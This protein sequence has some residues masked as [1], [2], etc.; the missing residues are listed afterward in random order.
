SRRPARARC[1][2]CRWRKCSHEELAVMKRIDWDLLDE[3]GHR[4]ALARPAQSR[5]AELRDGVG[6][7]IA[8]VRARGDV[9]L[10]ELSAKYD[11]CTLMELEAT[12]AEFAEAETMLDPALKAAIHEAAARI[13]AFHR[14]ARRSR[15]AWTPH[16][17]CGWSAC[18]ARSAA[19][20]C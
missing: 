14:A 3:Q 2:C 20:V 18:C 9:A 4:E 15:W 10:R 16:P 11:R 12:E 6:R 1:S 19:W 5:A 13:E 17:A 8:E 7:I